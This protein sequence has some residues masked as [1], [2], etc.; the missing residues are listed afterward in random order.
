[1]KKK[2]LEDGTAEYV[3][4]GAYGIVYSG[5]Y[6]NCQVAL[7]EIELKSDIGLTKENALKEAEVLLSLRHPGV[8]NYYGY[9]ERKAYGNFPKEFI[10][11]VS[12]LHLNGSLDNYINKK[13][14]SL[15]ERKAL[16][17]Q[18]AS[19]L[20]YLHSKKIVHR[21]LKPENVLIS[22]SG[23]AV[24]S[25]FGLSKT[26]KTKYVG[27]INSMAGTL[28][29]TAPEVLLSQ[30]SDFSADVYSFGIMMYE[31]LCL[32]KPYSGCIFTSEMDFTHKVSEKSP[33]ALRPDL[34]IIEAGLKTE[35]IS[36]MKKCWS[37][38]TQ[39]RPTFKQIIEILKLA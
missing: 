25:D 36:L 7:K 17:I 30:P 32:I 33:N 13:F 9:Y 3:G 26:M 12:D 31:V 35:I 11:F 29:Y 16:L 22:D 24:L 20:D 14:P 4:N 6:G 5:F 10:V 21:D 2:I 28:W 37:W 38:N 34:S 1:V 8:L 39:E 18:V 27:A 15:E 23:D 19:A